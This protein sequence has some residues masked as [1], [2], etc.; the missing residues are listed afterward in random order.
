MQIRLKGKIFMQ[1]TKTSTITIVKRTKD[2]ERV[3]DVKFTEQRGN[4]HMD[5]LI[6]NSLLTY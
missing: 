1:I 6:T 3:V 2:I 5:L 4:K